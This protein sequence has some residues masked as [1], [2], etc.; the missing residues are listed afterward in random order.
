MDFWNRLRL[1]SLLLPGAFLLVVAVLIIRLDLPRLTVSVVDLYFYT[2]FPV[3]LL[4]AWRFHSGRIFCSLVLL[5]L[6]QLALEFFSSQGAESGLT[7]LEAISFLL[8][9]NLV[10]LGMTAERGFT[11]PALA[12]RFLVLFIESTIVAIISRPAPGMGAHL[13]HGSLLNPS[14][15]A[16]TRIPQISWLAFS[17]AMGVLVT[18]FLKHHKPVE[19]GFTWCLLGSF[20]GVHAEGVGTGARAYFAT[21][22]VILGASIIETSYSMAYHDELT[23]LPSRRAFNDALL[24]LEAPYAVAVVDVD[25][26]KRVNDTYGHDAG[27]DVLGMVAGRLARVSGGGRAF[28]IGGEEF[29][30]LF[31]GHRAQDVLEHLESVRASIEG[32]VFR[33]RGSDRRTAPRG[34]ERRKTAGPRKKS[35][36]R[37]RRLPSSPTAGQLSVTVSIGVAEPSSQDTSV[38]TVIDL[39]DKALY[40]AKESGR[41]RVELAT[42]APRRDDQRKA[43]QDSA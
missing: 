17:V 13:F 21:S 3:A 16:W 19:G 36:R 15:F 4:L 23:G 11:M 42:V 20:L 33:T 39:A 24:R 38:H 9:V 27:D 30:I 28:R 22:A 41:N 1:K 10:L 31:P 12:P 32:A 40:R 18:R 6:A 25:H 7:A 37:R 8:P 34:P 26:F 29:V 5:L 14:W 35:S 43:A 2:A